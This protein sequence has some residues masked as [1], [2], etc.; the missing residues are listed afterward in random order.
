MENDEKIS[1]KSL[2]VV[3]GIYNDGN[4]L[5]SELRKQFGI[6][7]T[8]VFRWFNGSTEPSMRD[9]RALI[10]FATANKDKL[11]GIRDDIDELL[12]MI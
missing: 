7:N 8:T 6:S 2:E 9:K 11:K 4:M 3:S 5:R 12:Q 10:L 1:K